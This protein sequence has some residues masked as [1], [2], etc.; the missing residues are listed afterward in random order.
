MSCFHLTCEF[1]RVTRIQ[2]YICTYVRCRLN[3]VSYT[4]PGLLPLM[5]GSLLL[6]KGLKGRAEQKRGASKAKVAVK[7]EIG[8]SATSIGTSNIQGSS[9]AT[10]SK[11]DTSYSS[12]RKKST[13]YSY[14]QS[15]IPRSSSALNTSKSNK[16][17][18]ESSSG[19]YNSST[20]PSSVK[21]TQGSELE[22][23]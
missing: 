20:K 3:R 12:T 9:M 6:T 10:S 13:D 22:I 14:R 21:N 1:R 2:S 17:S 23:Q 16:S 18:V 11:S 5:F 7:T 8:S 15:S 19:E 4:V